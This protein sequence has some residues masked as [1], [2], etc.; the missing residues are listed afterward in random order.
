MYE[1]NLANPVILHLN[2]IS[3][4]SASTGGLLGLFMGF[5]VLSLVEIIYFV[6][7]RPY[8]KNNRDKQ[9][10]K[11]KKEP[12]KV[13]NL[14]DLKLKFKTGSKIAWLK[15]DTAGVDEQYTPFPYIE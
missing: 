11:D 1:L 8:C 12:K 15:Y 4:F 9:R 10:V 6:S 2:S 3:V 13:K 7:L 14:G 5:S